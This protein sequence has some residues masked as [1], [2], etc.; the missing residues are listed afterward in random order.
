MSCCIVKVYVLCDTSVLREII[1][2]LFGA[3]FFYSHKRPK[4]SNFFSLDLKGI[5]SHQGVCSGFKIIYF[6]HY[7][8][9]CMRC[10][11]IG[12]LSRRW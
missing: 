5:L 4:P 1:A 2:Q 7:N 12:A 6:W 3:N 10:V 9:V 8:H 11:D